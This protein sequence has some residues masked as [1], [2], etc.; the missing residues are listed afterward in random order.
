[1]HWDE[2]NQKNVRK[3]FSL[4]SDERWDDFKKLLV[5]N[6]HLIRLLTVEIFL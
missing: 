2:A 1:M 6:A 3:L 4:L 5:Q